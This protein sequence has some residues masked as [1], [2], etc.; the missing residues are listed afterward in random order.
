MNEKEFYILTLILNNGYTTQR[1]LS[2]KSSLSLGSV[3]KILKNLVKNGYI[4]EN[5]NLTKISKEILEKR[6]PKNAIILAAGNSFKMGDY[7]NTP[8][9][10]LEVKGEILIERIIK[11]LKEIDIK[12]IYIVVG[13]MKEKFEYLIDKFSVKLI[14]NT[15][16]NT[17]N[18]LY[19][20]NISDFEKEN[21]YIIPSDLYFFKN[22]FS[23]YEPYSWY[24]LSNDFS[25]NSNISINRKGQIILSYKKDFNNKMV[26][27]SYILKEDGK[28]IKN[29]LMKFSN[30]LNND[31][32]FWE[33]TLFKKEK[34]II[35]AKIISKEDFFEINTYEDF[36]NVD[37]FLIKNEAIDIIKKVFNVSK[38]EILDI[39]VFKKGMTN[40]SFTFSINKEKYIIRM[41]GKGTDNL[42]NR[43][44]EFYVYNV[45]NNKNICDDIVYINPKN[46]YKISK[47]FENSRCCDKNNKDDLK[48]CIKKLKEFHNLKLKVN[49]EFNLFK[50]IDF[51]M[52]LCKNKNS[53]Y[54]DFDETY[55]NIKSLENFIDS[56]KKEKC[57]THIDANCD[58]FLFTKEGVKLIDFEYA[59]MQDPHLDIA[60]FCIY[61]LYDKEQIDEIIDIYFENKCSIENRIKIYAYI[62]ISGLLWSNWC[63]YK[64]SFGIEFGEYS[65]KQYHYAK[66]FYK[67]TKNLKEKY[68]L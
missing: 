53:I 21:S 43:K 11:Q 35:H 22:P 63:E 27:L 42:I 51:Y 24:M 65:I 6:K 40:K 64:L 23:Y 44:E 61:S 38:K 13:F 2:K 5:M 59:A 45:I 28:I 8:K 58:N 37:D 55:K 66:E 56:I 14:I 57:L 47:F 60:M 17:K 34:M 29:N 4:D 7:F 19:S 46:G 12:N 39:K 54:K 15:N 48:I 20:L 31:Y 36:L 49:H 68:K 16:Y 33:S 67:L 30:Y 18:N 3:N 1:Y 52:S 50:K 10:L 41:P 9:A 32:L 26:G 62:A 25:K